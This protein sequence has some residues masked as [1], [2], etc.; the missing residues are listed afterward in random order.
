MNVRNFS[1]VWDHDCENIVRC[2]ECEKQFDRSSQLEKHK[3]AHGGEKPFQCN[4]CEISLFDIVN[5]TIHWIIH[6]SKNPFECNH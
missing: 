2:K 4:E 5:K 3:R 6:N 1:L